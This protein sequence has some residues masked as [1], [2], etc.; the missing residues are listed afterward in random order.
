MMDG[1]NDRQPKSNI[2]PTFSKQ[3]IINAPEVICL[4]KLSATCECLHQKTNFRIQAN[5]V[6]SDQTAT[7]PLA[8]TFQQRTLSNSSRSYEI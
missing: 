2:A 7:S 1:R 5:S 4:L 3:G 6:D 8:D